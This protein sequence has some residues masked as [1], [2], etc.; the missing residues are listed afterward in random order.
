M[1]KIRLE[2]PSSGSKRIWL[3]VTGNL[4]EPFYDKLLTKHVENEKLGTDKIS[5]YI[6]VPEDLS[7]IEVLGLGGTTPDND[8][9]M[10]WIKFDIFDDWHVPGL[11]KVTVFFDDR[12]HEVPV[13]NGRPDKKE[14]DYYRNDENNGY[15]F[16]KPWALAVYTFVD[17]TIAAFHWHP[18][19]IGYLKSRKRAIELSK[20]MFPCMWEK[21]GQVNPYTGSATLICNTNGNKKKPLFINRKTNLICG[22]HALIVVDIGNIIVEMSYE[23][24][25]SL[26]GDNLIVFNINL[27]KITYIDK[28]ACTVDVETIAHIS[29]ILGYNY[30]YKEMEDI[31]SHFIHDNTSTAPYKKA[32]WT[33]LKKSTCLKCRKPMYIKTFV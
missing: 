11:E 22:N 33:A 15:L 31:V 30:N 6:D 7:L 24:K 13:E 21:G 5:M 14:W 23:K 3:K 2:F 17:K 1:K 27:L 10:S 20:N 18:N 12:I 26:Y 8:I 19:L 32:I 25:S 9:S 4:T 16:M 28:K 29:D